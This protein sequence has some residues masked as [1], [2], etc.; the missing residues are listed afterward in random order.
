VVRLDLSSAAFASAPMPPPAAAPAPPAP[1]S[2]KWELIVDSAAIPAIRFAVAQSAITP[3]HV[4][5]IRGA[6]ERVKAIDGARNV[7]LRIVGHTDSS[8]IAGRLRDKIADNWALSR[9]RADAAAAHLREQLGL[10]PGMTE[11]DG[12]ADT[13]PVADNATPEGRALNRRVEVQVL[14]EKKSSGG[15]SAAGK[16]AAPASA[17]PAPAAPRSA[18]PQWLQ[19]VG[20]LLDEL[21]KKPS[22]VRLGYCRAPGE[23]IEAARFR[24]YQAKREIESRWR[25]VPDRYVLI[26][27]QELDGASCPG[28]RR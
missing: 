8:P 6:L 11:T 16:D 13:V 2:E 24:L 10:S 26:V 21:G 18:G 20:S 19:A 7:R 22:V 3:E 25:S 27:E 23:K 14:Y 12:R 28:A 17:A 15:S 5:L 1:P 9:F 4:A